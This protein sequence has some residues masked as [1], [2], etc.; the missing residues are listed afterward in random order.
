[1]GFPAFEAA[2]ETLTKLLLPSVVVVTTVRSL[3]ALYRSVY[4]LP[5]IDKFPLRT[6]ANRTGRP[7]VC[8]SSV[9]PYSSQTSCV[10][11]ASKETSSILM[12]ADIRDFH[13]LN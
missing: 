8:V 7:I 5:Q 9:F 1:M 13:A 11:A 2:L 4:L 3:S 10:T 6:C 12:L